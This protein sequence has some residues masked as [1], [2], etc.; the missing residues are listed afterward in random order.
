MT[1]DV[2]ALDLRGVVAGF[3]GKTVLRGISFALGAGERMALVGPNGAGKTTLLNVA[4]GRVPCSKGEVS[5]FGRGLAGIPARE[6]AHLVGMAGQTLETPMAFTVAEIVM[7][8]RIARLGRLRAPASSDYEA[9]AEAMRSTRTHDFRE[10]RFQ[11]LSS[12]EKQRVSIAL[13]L[14][15]EPRLLLMDEAT[16]H[17][18]M[19]HRLEILELVEE[20]GRKRGLAVMMVMHDLNLAAEFFPRVALM[21]AGELVADGPPEAVFTSEL[22]GQVYGCQVDV[23]RDELAGCLRIFAGKKRRNTT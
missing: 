12:G 19:N 9:V 2:G 14:A 21:R 7:M 13:A 23:R 3:G 5:L 15:A 6:R 1:G 11:T 18:D 8:G 17:L 20:F 4:M 22:L 16:A 10:R